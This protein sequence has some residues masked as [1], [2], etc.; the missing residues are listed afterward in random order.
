[1]PS[2]RTIDLVAIGAGA[3]RLASGISF[4]ATP[5]KAHKTFTG[6]ATPDP[7]TSI[8]LRSMGYRDALIGALLLGSGLGGGTSTK[9]FLVSA[10][11]DAA[12]LAGTVAAGHG[13][14]GREKALALGGAGLGTA[15]GLYGA[16]RSVRR[17]HRRRKAARSN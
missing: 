6:N 14:G 15:I 12:D 9:W 7:A 4:L 2:L 13:I 11:A 10:G 3:T 5:E 17:G 16:V 8:L 1:M